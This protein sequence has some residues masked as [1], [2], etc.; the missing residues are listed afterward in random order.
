MDTNM[1]NKINFPVLLS[2][3]MDSKLFMLEVNGSS[4]INQNY[5]F[6]EL[7]VSL[8]IKTISEELS[9]NVNI[10]E[11]KDKM[12]DKIQKELDELNKKMYQINQALE[13]SN[14]DLMKIGREHY[15]NI[16]NDLHSK[17]NEMNI[18]THMMEYQILNDKLEEIKNTK[19]IEIIDTNYES[20][21][22]LNQKNNNA[23]ISLTKYNKKIYLNLIN[24]TNIVSVK[25]VTKVVD[26]IDINLINKSFIRKDKK[27]DSNITIGSNVFSLWKGRKNSKPFFA[28]VTHIFVHDGLT[29]YELKYIDGDVST[30][31]YD[32]VRIV[33]QGT[34]FTCRGNNYTIIEKKDIAKYKCR[35]HFNNMEMMFDFST[36]Q[37]DCL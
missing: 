18:V 8:T 23:I 15:K 28:T 19:D 25:H 10:S 20:S 30:E 11:K 37:I 36:T 31:N 26:K 32:T 22:L 2:L 9:V 1:E 35:A 12:C 3:A 34:E 16:K 24:P 5:T 7:I 17:E 21:F 14:I 4:N 33:C 13:K 6:D 27:M 29:K